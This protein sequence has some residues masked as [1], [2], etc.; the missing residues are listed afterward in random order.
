MAGTNSFAQRQARREARIEESAQP[1]NVKGGITFQTSVPY[2]KAYDGALTYLKRQGYTIETAG[3]E[4]GQI[5]TAMD[6]K[7][8]Y[9]QTGTRVQVTCIKD[10]DTQTSM[11]VLVTDQKR[12]KALQAEPWS[13]PKANNEEST[14]IGEELK[15]ALQGTA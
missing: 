5:I 8:G 4:T 10:S 12:K 9:S 14:K 2:D 15:A 1:R 11:R 6:V 7:G 3:K 13:E